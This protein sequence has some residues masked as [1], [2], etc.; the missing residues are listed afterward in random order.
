M[1]SGMS[2]FDPARASRFYQ[3]NK[4]REDSKLP[5]VYIAVGTVK[6]LLGDQASSLDALE[7]AKELYSPAPNARILQP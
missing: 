1:F 4:D 3:E 7:K 6:M 2:G 5:D